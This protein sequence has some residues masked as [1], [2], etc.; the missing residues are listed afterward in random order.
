[1]K[2][3]ILNIGKALNKAEQKTI[4]GG[5]MLAA[6]CRG[7]KDMDTGCLCTSGDQC[8]SGSCR[9]SRGQIFGNCR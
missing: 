9:K 8:S 5:H 4:N 3:Q 1:M 6:P 7:G 2:K